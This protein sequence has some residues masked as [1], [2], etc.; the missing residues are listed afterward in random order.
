MKRT[1]EELI[2]A[3]QAIVGE[4]ND[5]EV[6]ALFEDIAD[7]FV[8]EVVEPTDEVQETEDW[9]AKYEELDKSWREKYIARFTQGTV[10]TEDTPEDSDEELDKMVSIEDLDI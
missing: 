10:N 9:K 2:S 5:D 8:E 7:S 3:V 1:P 6:I 4:R